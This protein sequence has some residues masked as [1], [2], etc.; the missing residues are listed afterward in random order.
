M[1][2]LANFHLKIMDNAAKR[3]VAHGQTVPWFDIDSISGDNC[4]ADLD[5]KGGKDITLF[6]IDIIQQSQIS[7][8]VRVIFNGRN[9]CRNIDF[10]PLEI[11][12]P[13]FPFMTSTNM[14]GC[15]ATVV[16]PSP[17]LAKGA[18]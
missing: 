11:D 3:H 14:P 5:A 9:F 10:F 6:T 4:I 13:I 1:R 7:G 8:T 2:T 17:G 18:N 12:Q 15:Y 16:I